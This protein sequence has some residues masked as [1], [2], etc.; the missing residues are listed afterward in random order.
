ML[1][2]YLSII[3]PMTCGCFSFP[4]IFR[5]FIITFFL[6]SNYSDFFDYL[7][8]ANLFFMNEDHMTAQMFLYAPMNKDTMKNP[9]IAI[10]MK[11][12]FI[13]S[14]NDALK[15]AAIRVVLQDLVLGLV[16]NEVYKKSFELSCQNLNRSTLLFSIRIGIIIGLISILPAFI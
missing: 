16:Q 11:T 13:H 3:I 5:R 4:R 14:R 9:K 1:Y 15:G 8:M 7:S 2:R 6:N 12:Q 10:L